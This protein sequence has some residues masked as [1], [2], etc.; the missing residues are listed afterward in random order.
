MKN[1]YLCI[2]NMSIIGL[3][4]VIVVVGGLVLYGMGKDVPAVVWAMGGTLIGSL[5]SFLVTP[6]A[7]SIGLGRSSVPP[8]NPGT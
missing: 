7:N 5:T 4:A 1:P 2:L 8:S 6:A 3:L